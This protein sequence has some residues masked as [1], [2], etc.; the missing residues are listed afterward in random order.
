MDSDQESLKLSVG[1]R[2]CLLV[3]GM[4]LCG[5]QHVEI[6]ISPLTSS[7]CLYITFDN[8]WKARL[9]PATSGHGV[10]CPVPVGRQCF[11]CCC[12]NCDPHPLS[13]PP[14][15]PWE[16]GHNLCDLDHQRIRF[17]QVFVS[18][19][20]SKHMKGLKKKKKK[21]LFIMLKHDMRIFRVSPFF[22]LR[23]NT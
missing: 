21:A 3:Q 10:S 9:F 23:D 14:G 15:T 8:Q 19:A 11:C 18:S 6:Q 16:A 22:K 1:L 12:R 4:A 20:G 17:S 13:T 7:L 5:G 2:Q